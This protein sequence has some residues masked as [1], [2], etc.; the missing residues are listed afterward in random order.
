MW[1]EISEDLGFGWQAFEFVLQFFI[2]PVVIFVGIVFLFPKLFRNTSF[3]QNPESNRWYVTVQLVIT[4]LFIAVWELRAQ[5]GVMIINQFIFNCIIITGY[6]ST[7]LFYP[8]VNKKYT[9][10]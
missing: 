7:A 5:A 8:G 6:F 10:S 3:F 4:A 1:K 9:N 2:L